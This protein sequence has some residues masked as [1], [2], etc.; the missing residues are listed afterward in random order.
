MTNYSYDY[1]G[2]QCT[3]QSPDIPC[4]SLYLIDCYNLWRLIDRSQSQNFHVNGINFT[5]WHKQLYCWKVS[6]LQPWDVETFCHPTLFFDLTPYCS[7][8]LADTRSALYMPKA[9]DPPPPP[10]P[11][12]YSPSRIRLCLSLCCSLIK[13]NGSA[14]F[15]SAWE[16]V[17]NKERNGALEIQ[18]CPLCLYGDDR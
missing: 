6:I 1:Y 4:L 15:C 18:D 16:V 8:P 7:L 12:L 11:P 2:G 13:D 17:N 3:I 9:R 5:S 14:G 10:T